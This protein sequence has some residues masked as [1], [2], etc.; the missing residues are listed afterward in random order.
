MKQNETELYSAAANFVKAFN[1]DL[2]SHEE[3]EI[4]LFSRQNVTKNVW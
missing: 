2:I 3:V 1:L 4:Y